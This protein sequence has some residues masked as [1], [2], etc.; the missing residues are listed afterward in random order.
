[1][2]QTL[3][4]DKNV[5]R[6]LIAPVYNVSIVEKTKKRCQF[7]LLPIVSDSTAKNAMECFSYINKTSAEKNIP[8]RKVGMLRMQQKLLQVQR[9]KYVIRQR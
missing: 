6:Q 5:I 2:Y 8:E 7:Y 1:M 4:P 9:P 3:Q